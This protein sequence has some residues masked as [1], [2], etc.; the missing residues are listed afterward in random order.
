MHVFLLKLL[1]VSFP[2]NAAVLE[3]VAFIIKLGQISNRYS[4]IVLLMLALWEIHNT[5]Y[6]QW[7]AI[8]SSLSE[9]EKILHLATVMWLMETVMVSRQCILSTVTLDTL[10][11]ISFL[12][13]KVWGIWT[14]IGFIGY[15]GT[16]K[17]GFYFANPS[18]CSWNRPKICS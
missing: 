18:W 9:T 2:W 1:K 16:S 17:P 14:K 12:E 15:E 8:L 5:R 11:W 6:I 3:K 13:R 10:L 7:Y 4:K